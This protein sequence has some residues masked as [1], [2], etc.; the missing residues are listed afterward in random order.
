[1][2]LIS[3]I[4]PHFN[5]AK[6]LTETL[7]SVK[8]QSYVKWEIIIVD[9]G[10]SSEEY[11]AVATLIS[12]DSR[13]KLHK[14]KSEKKGPSICR[15]EG[16][17]LSAGT[18]IIFLDSDDLLESSCI[19]RRVKQMLLNPRTDVGIFNIEKFYTFPGD[20][21]Q[22]FSQHAINRSAYLNM[23]LSLN[24]PWQVMAPIWTKKVLQKLGGFNE[25]M[26]YA[27]DPELHTRALLD[28]SIEFNFFINSKPDCFYRMASVNHQNS[29]EDIRKSIMGRI[30]FLII[31]HQSIIAN[32]SQ[33]SFLPKS[34][35]QSYKKGYKN[36]FSHFLNNSGYS[37]SHEFE[38]ISS[39]FKKYKL[40]SN[41]TFHF[42]KLVF[43]AW[44]REMSI[45]KY[46]PLK[47]FL[48]KLY[49]ISS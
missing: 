21:N 41:S 44:Q 12:E 31:T 9:D 8:K 39:Y 35:R 18:Y 10:S 1:M 38:E 28:K 46:I 3:I 19:E 43:S 40:I 37:L 6:L 45:N 14:R 25:N 33:N 4:I 36:V 23:F 7:Q 49:L 24:I 2:D 42:S 11:N 48:T 34:V 26:N 47:G 20:A 29:S 17:R 5:R 30:Q 13:I 22:I 32:N 27:E 15:N 16:I